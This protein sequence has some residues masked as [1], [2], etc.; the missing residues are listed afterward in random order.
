L[1]E[2]FNTLKQ[3]STPNVKANPNLK[4]NLKFNSDN[5]AKTPNA[6]VL[7][8]NQ[9]KSDQIFKKISMNMNS[10]KTKKSKVNE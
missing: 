8:K 2:E 1:V 6:K 10:L 5:M 7:N 9:M 4:G 3:S